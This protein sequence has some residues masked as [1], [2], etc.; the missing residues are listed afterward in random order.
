MFDIFLSENGSPWKRVRKALT[1]SLSLLIHALVIAAFIVVPLLRADA[2][3]SEYRII[4][5][6]LIAPPV[7]PGVPPGP[8][9]GK[10]PPAGPAEPSTGPKAPPATS[11]PRG[12]MAPIEIPTEIADENPADFIADDPGGPGVEGGSGDGKTPWIFGK[13]ILSEEV[14]PSE[15]AIITIRAPRLIKRVNP[16]YSITAINAR[17]SGAVEIEACT[18]IY[19][20]VIEAH[21]VRGH[22]LLNGTALEAIKKWIYEPYLVNGIPKPVRFKVTITFTLETR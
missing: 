16:E 8:G 14:K 12:F 2:I 9:R 4:D 7:V 20:R 22:A 19:G 13:D 11:G 21:V 3:L 5:T 1:F 6:A 10:K 17:V 18:D 15:K